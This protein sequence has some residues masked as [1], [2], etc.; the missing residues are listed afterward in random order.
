MTKFFIDQ[1]GCSKNQ[2]DGELII[3]Y[4]TKDGYEQTFDV[5]KAD[6][7][8]VNSCGFI[9]SAKRE[10]LD[11]VYFAKEKYPNAKVLLAGCLAERY[12]KDFESALP[13]ADA[14]F[15]NGDISKI[16]EAAANALESK[17]NSI[18][19]AQEGI[20]CA[21]RKMMLSFPGSAYVKITEGCNNRCAFCAIP[22]IRGNLRSRNASEIIDEIK[23]LISEGVFE[24]NL[25]G[26]DLAS[27]GAGI[28]DNVFGDGRTK[29]PHFDSD[30]NRLPTT[31]KSGLCRLL[32]EI[33]KI[34]GNFWIRLLYID[35]DSFNNDI[36]E[37]I[38]KD[39]RIL[40]YFDMPFQ[41]GSSD[42]IRKMCRKSSSAAYVNVIENIRNVLPD[43]SIRTTFLAGFPGETEKDAKETEEFLNKI[44]PDWSG[45]FPYS[46]EEGTSAAK[47][48][49][50]VPKKIA[51]QRAESIIKIQNEI[52][53]QK[54]AN[55]VGKDYD[56]LIEEIIQGENDGIAIGRAWFQ[57][58]DVDGSVVVRY[59]KENKAEC[60][61]VQPGH[62]IKAHADASTDL[63][64]DAS[65]IS[66]TEFMRGDFLKSL[67]FAPLLVK[68]SETNG[69]E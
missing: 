66:G 4:L 35:P 32:E 26:Q 55:R 44:K 59:N 46:K 43:A 30:G 29:L 47:A 18:I 48:K 16:S 45:C 5:S 27:Y 10:S 38:K 22:L 24:L 15:G 21:P 63:D 19:T 56:V 64:L 28:K 7:I 37:V 12:A 65:F 40:H 1:H 17:H 6:L 9:E 23:L 49:K 20:S 60:E 41:S 68:D 3:H 50:F 39:N 53:K 8:V 36:L 58:P 33:S 67:S 51:E 13:E 14:F 25:I 61:L 57:A 31:E 69:D 62:L 54:I 11:A 2:V 34:K 42:V 52:T